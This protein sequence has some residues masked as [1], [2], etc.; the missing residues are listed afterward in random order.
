MVGA[1]G[2][3]LMNFHFKVEGMRLELWFIVF[4][5]WF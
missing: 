5:I 4:L 3:K 2:Y 1:E